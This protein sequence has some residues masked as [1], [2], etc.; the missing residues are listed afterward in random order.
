MLII[1][2]NRSSHFQCFSSLYTQPN[3]G[4]C[5]DLQSQ[6]NYNDNVT[7][8]VQ[9]K[10][11]SRTFDQWVK[12]MREKRNQQ[13]QFAFLVSTYCTIG[14]FVYLLFLAFKFSVNTS[15]VTSF[16]SFFPSLILFLVIMK[17]NFLLQWG[18]IG[19]YRDV[20]R[21]FFSAW[22]YTHSLQWVSLYTSYGNAL[23]AFPSSISS[24]VSGASHRG[25]SSVGPLKSMMFTWTAY[26]W[27]KEERLLYEDGVLSLSRIT[28]TP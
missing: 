3:L 7:L 9:F 16:K 10:Q 24:G 25:R 18:G 17:N 2:E 12:A 11:L 19:E 20:Y 28:C 8:S 14:L 22:N 4:Y 23:M 13:T 6:G 15:F 1:E 27:E 5:L 26:M 21:V